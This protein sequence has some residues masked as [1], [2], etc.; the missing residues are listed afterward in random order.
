MPIIGNQ[1]YLSID[2]GLSMNGS[3]WRLLRPAV[4][5]WLNFSAKVQVVFQQSPL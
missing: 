5:G 4:V 2:N 1:R 3:Y